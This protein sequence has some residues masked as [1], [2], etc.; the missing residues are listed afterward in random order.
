MLRA[1]RVTVLVDGRRVS[2]PAL[3]SGVATV[4]LRLARGTHTIRAS[5]AGSAHVAGAVATM[6]V[7]ARR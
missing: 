2:V 5:Y 1:G 3:R 7:T 6:R 4:S